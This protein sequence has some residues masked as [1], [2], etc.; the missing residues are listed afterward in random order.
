M[1][2]PWEVKNHILKSLLQAENHKEAKILILNDSRSFVICPDL[3]RLGNDLIDFHIF[4]I[5][6]HFYIWYNLSVV[7][8]SIF[9]VH[10]SIFSIRY[11]SAT[12]RSDCLYFLCVCFNMIWNTPSPFSRRWKYWH[13]WIYLDIL[14]QCRKWQQHGFT[15]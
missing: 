15:I 4:N 2:K 8:E 12:E 10:Y 13:P 11:F 7:V 14:L 1:Y 3:F 5:Y 9:I 6:A